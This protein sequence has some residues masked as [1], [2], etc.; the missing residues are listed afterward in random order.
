MNWAGKGQMSSY[1]MI[2]SPLIY[3]IPQHQQQLHSHFI[4]SRKDFLSLLQC[5]SMKL[6]SKPEV[7]AA[8]KLWNQ[9]LDITNLEKSNV[10][11]WGSVRAS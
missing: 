2:V 3:H 5:Q 8:E 6:G 11:T 7:Q 1:L 9:T 10:Q 4:K